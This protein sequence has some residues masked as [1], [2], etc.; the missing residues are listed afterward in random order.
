MN[1]DITPYSSKENKKIQVTQMFDKIASRYDLLNHSLSLR[2]GFCL[3]KNSS[4]KF[5]K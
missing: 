4:K 3:E 5:N 2:N 1:K